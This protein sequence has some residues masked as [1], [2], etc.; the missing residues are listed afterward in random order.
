MRVSDHVDTD[1]QAPDALAI[2]VA[3]LLMDFGRTIW[4]VSAPGSLL[5][6]ILTIYV[7]GTAIGLIV[8][9]ISTIDLEEHGVAIAAFVTAA[10]G[11]TVLV[12]L[13]SLYDAPIVTDVGRFLHEATLLTING[14][15]PYENELVANRSTFPTPTMDGGTVTRYSY[16]AGAIVAMVPQYALGL[17]SVRVTPTLASIAIGFV[18]LKD[19]PGEFALLAPATLLAGDLV[20]WPLSGL[21][22]SLWILP[23]CLAVI[24]WRNRLLWSGVAYGFAASVEQ[25]PWFIGPFLLIW[26]LRDRGREAAGYWLTASLGMF[27]LVNLPFLIWGPEAWL[28]GALQPL[29]GSGSPPVHQGVG[30]SSLTVFGVFPIAKWAHT[31]L[32]GLIAVIA[33]TLYYRKPS[34]RWTGWIAWMPLIFVHFRSFGLYFSAGLPVVAVAYLQRGAENVE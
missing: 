5:I 24:W 27:A 23:L 6:A 33:L 7:W 21:V 20:T 22:D 31:A 2:I 19:A 26:L 32:V 12:A 9:G 10:I 17:S 25:I 16:P 30:L 4:S 15:N 18:V 28:T 8:V 14:E 34:L 1:V 3:V 11:S 13:L 29:F